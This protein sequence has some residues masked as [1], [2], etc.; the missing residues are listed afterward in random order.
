MWLLFLPLAG[1]VPHASFSQWYQGILPWCHPPEKVD[2][3]GRMLTLISVYP[4]PP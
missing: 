3:S 1:S 2:E 4:H